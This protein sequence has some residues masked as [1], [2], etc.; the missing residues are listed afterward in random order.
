VGIP[1]SKVLLAV[2]KTISNAQI[3][4]CANDSNKINLIKV[5][6][7]LSKVLLAGC[8][9]NE[10][11]QCPPLLEADMGQLED[12]GCWSR[13]CSFWLKLMSFFSCE[14]DI[15]SSEQDVLIWLQLMAF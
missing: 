10:D 7:L 5:G 1:T 8:S 12:A 9:A 6:V 11:E 2:Q 14:I 15:Q 4:E 13:T 3:I